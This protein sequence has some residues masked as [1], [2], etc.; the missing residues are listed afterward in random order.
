MLHFVLDPSNRN[1]NQFLFNMDNI[2]YYLE[3][4]ALGDEI[5]MHRNILL[6]LLEKNFITNEIIIYCLSD[7]SFLYTKIFKMYFVMKKL[8]T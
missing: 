4:H 1:D 2:I 7:R 8:E 3:A 6:S 5:H